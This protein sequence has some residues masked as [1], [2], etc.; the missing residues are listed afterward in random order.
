[1]VVIEDR[2]A[3][4][5]C[6]VLL[7]TDLNGWAAAQEFCLQL[8]LYDSESFILHPDEAVIAITSRKTE[9]LY[10]ATAAICR[11]APDPRTEMTNSVTGQETGCRTHRVCKRRIDM[12]NAAMREADHN[13]RERTLLDDMGD[14]LAPP[15]YPATEYRD[16]KSRQALQREV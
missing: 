11:P 2:Q 9:R 4:G 15:I 5:F 13:G 10:H 12:I 6:S 8:G 3:L 1:M 14:G 7:A 16:K